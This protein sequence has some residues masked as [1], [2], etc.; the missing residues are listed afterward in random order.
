MMTVRD[1]AAYLQM[2]TKYVYKLV[3]S[4]QLPHYKFGNRVGI[5]QN[6]LDE[7][8]KS[9]RVEQPTPSKGGRVSLKHITMGA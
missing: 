1:A 6:D 5:D 4:G 2:S 7:F 8:V 9:C 3:E